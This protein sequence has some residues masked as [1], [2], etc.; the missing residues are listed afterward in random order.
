[1][2]GVAP[3]HGGQGTVPGGVGIERLGEKAALAQG[4][5]DTYCGSVILSAA[6]KLKLVVSGVE[7]RVK[8]SLQRLDQGQ[9]GQQVGNE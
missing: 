5:G 7:V 9:I 1:M 8:G 6:D 3:T 4:A 2:F